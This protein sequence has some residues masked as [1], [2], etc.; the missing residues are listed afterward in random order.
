[1]IIDIKPEEG[2]ALVEKFSPKVVFEYANVTS[3]ESV[4][5]AI[6]TAK[7]RFGRINGLINSAGTGIFVKTA[8]SRS[9]H[10]F[11]LFKRVID[12]NLT[13]TFNVSRLVAYEM[14][15]QPILEGRTER[16]VII[17]VSSI[18]AYEGQIGQAAYSASKGGIVSM[19]LVMAR[20]LA[21]YKI[22]GKNSNFLNGV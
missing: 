10:D 6:E 20:D 16:G 5:K 19:T 1:M 15:K 11:E 22:R 2:K 13:G 8:T 14:I 7:S 18:A 12:V 9:P 17:H 3:E 4:K 21:P